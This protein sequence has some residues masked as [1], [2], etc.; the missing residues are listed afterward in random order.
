MDFKRGFCIWKVKKKKSKVFQEK[1]KVIHR[2]LQSRRKGWCFYLLLTELLAGAPGPMG[3]A[4]CTSPRTPWAPRP[5]SASS[6]GLAP[7]GMRG[8]SP[9]SKIC[10]L[11]V[12][13]WDSTAASMLIW[14][15]S[16]LLIALPG[17]PGAQRGTRGWARKKV[18][19]L[20]WPW[21]DGWWQTPLKPS[22][23]SLLAPSWGT[24]LEW[25]KKPAHRMSIVPG[26]IQSWVFQVPQK[27]LPAS[28]V[29]E[30]HWSKI[31][32]G[33]RDFL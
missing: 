27:F 15:P 17:L 18:C 25:Q 5:A 10:A 24:R 14:L 20:R 13:W 9:T 8:K 31:S 21:C 16:Q 22:A 6:S 7:P 33:G 2:Q 4:R 30:A 32:T 11:S 3:R 19:A 29:T 12:A 28:L 26:Y 1:D 23:E